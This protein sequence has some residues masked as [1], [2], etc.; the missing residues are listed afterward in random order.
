[1]TDHVHMTDRAPA[2]R[3]LPLADRLLTLAPLLLALA[4]VVALAGAFGFEYVLGLEPCVLCIA[5]RYPFAAVIALGLVAALVPGNNRA[6]RVTLLT[7][8]GLVFLTGSGIAGFHVGVEQGWWE[9]TAGCSAPLPA[10]P[11]DGSLPDIDSLREQLLAQ[12]SVVPCDQPQWFF[13]GVTM[14]G[15]NAAGS[16]VLAVLAFAAAALTA[17]KT[18]A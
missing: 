10:L 5:Q 15:Y 7:L 4:S 2:G 3:P 18:A 6:V 11:A 8:C 16:L 12:T 1:M 14:A 13:L 17:R 9:G